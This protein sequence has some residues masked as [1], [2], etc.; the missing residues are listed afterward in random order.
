MAS[1]TPISCG[2]VKAFLV[3]GERDV[4]VDAGTPGSAPRIVRALESLGVDPA[5]IGLVVVTHGHADHTGGLAEIVQRTGARVVAHELEADHVRKGTMPAANPRSLATRLMLGEP[6]RSRAEGVEPA[7][8][9][10]DELDLG[11]HGVAGK[12]VHTPGHTAGSV[13]IVLDTG[14][15]IVGDLVLPAWI[16][17][18]PPRVAFWARSRGDSLASIRKL[19]DL[20]ARSFHCAHGGPFGRDALARLVS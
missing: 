5:G 11:E 2:F 13:S 1:V 17:A 15:A 7:V 19:L 6:G 20:G 4:L 16:V 3:R 9:V 14:E 18:G 12:V 8:L 10:E